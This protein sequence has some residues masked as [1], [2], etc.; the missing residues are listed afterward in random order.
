M[1]NKMLLMAGRCG[2]GLL[3]IG[4]ALLSTGAG[5]VHHS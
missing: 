2:L 1:K 4:S 5:V 3:L